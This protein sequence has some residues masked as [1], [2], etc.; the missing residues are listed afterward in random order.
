[1]GRARSAHDQPRLGHDLAHIDPPRQC[2]VDRIK[3]C[4]RCETA[5]ALPVRCSWLVNHQLEQRRGVGV[6]G[7]R[8]LSAI[9]SE[10][11]ATRAPERNAERR[12]CDS[13]ETLGALD[14]LP[15]LTGARRQLRGRPRSAPCRR[16]RRGPCRPGFE[17]AGGNGSLVKEV[18]C[19]GV[20]GDSRHAR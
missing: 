5:V 3:V 16:G 20:F 9:S 8:R 7:A 6:K 1:M 14:Y 13:E 4:G 17:G 19:A 12:L 2:Q 15:G 18:H 10:G 11:R